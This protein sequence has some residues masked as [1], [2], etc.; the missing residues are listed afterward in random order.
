M[1]ACRIVTA[2]LRRLMTTRS[3]T[4]IARKPTAVSVQASGDTEL[5]TTGLQAGGGTGTPGSRPQGSSLGLGE[6]SALT[7]SGFVLVVGRGCGHG[8]RG[9]RQLPSGPDQAG[10]GRDAE[11]PDDDRQG[12]P[13]R[14]RGD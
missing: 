8:A 1:V 7:G 12:E 5:N 10:D 13:D 11:H 14:D 3:R 4:T 6:R 9:G 2:S